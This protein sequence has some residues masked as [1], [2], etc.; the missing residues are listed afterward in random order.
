MVAPRHHT[1]RTDRPTRGA[2]V[3]KIALA[4]GRPLMPWQSDA[5]DVTSEFDPVTGEYVYGIVIVSTQRQSGKT[6][7]EG[8]VADHRALTIPRGRI[9]Y[10]AQTGKD[11]SAWMRDEHFPALEAAAVFGRPGS[12][13]CRYNRSKRAG[14]EGIDWKH[15]STFRVFPP[16]RDALHG[17]QSDLVF[18]DEAWSLSPEKGADVRQAI[19]PTMATR[20]GAQLWIVSTMGDDS[21]SFFDAYVELGRASLD[22]PNSRVCFV[23][24]GIG[25]DDDPEDLD[26][27]AA[28]HPAF[29]HTLTMQTLV[30]ARADFGDDVAGW[31]RAY[32][33]VPTR[34]RETAIPAGIWA[35]AG[36]SDP[37]VPDRVTPGLGIDVTP[38]LRRVAL[39]AGWRVQD[40]IPGLNVAAGDGFVQ[41]LHSGPN[42]RDF[43]ALVASVARARR[44]PVSADRASAGALEVMDALARHHPDVVQRITDT[45]AHVAACGQFERGVRDDTLHH[46]NDDGLNRAVEVATKRHLMDGG[47]VWGRKDS[48][49]S[50]VELVAAT[51]ALGA[52]DR[53]PKRASFRVLSATATRAGV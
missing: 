15:G 45:P 7:L 28:H 25:P 22:D 34:T 11:A 17:R 5:A 23:D 1:P 30:D 26:A 50:I 20:R 51:V 48:S 49:G 53:Q 4:K 19:R 16:L 46:L 35:A 36:R 27:I 37:G 24:Y 10:T 43:P 39:A 29:G 44:A 41:V 13:A 52:F 14:Q 18:V 3:R 47:F 32:G 12:P 38:D 33:N 8:D 40:D 31:A 6:A 9:W 42:D 2:G 21:S